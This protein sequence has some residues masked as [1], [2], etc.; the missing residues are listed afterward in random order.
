M[1]ITV[2]PADLRTIFESTLSDASLDAH[3]EVAIAIVD[4]A[5]TGTAEAKQTM[6]A[7]YLAAHVASVQAPRAESEK[8]SD[9]YSFK[10]QGVTGEGLKATFYGQTA[11]ALDTT[12]ALAELG[13][14]VAGLVAM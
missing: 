8:L 1:T 13:S 2:S 7:K 11:L 6:I 3:I 9:G 12:G 10:V 5:L 4:D 14:K